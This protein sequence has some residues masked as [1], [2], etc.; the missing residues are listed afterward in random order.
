MYDRAMFEFYSF[1]PLPKT[2]MNE[3]FGLDKNGWFVRVVNTLFSF[4]CYYNKYI[5]YQIKLHC[6]RF[7]ALI[8]LVTS[9]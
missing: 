6:I 7:D 4:Q 1:A 9:S 3:K 8:D 2:S 5:S